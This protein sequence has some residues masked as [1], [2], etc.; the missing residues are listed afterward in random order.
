MLDSSGQMQCLPLTRTQT[1]VWRAQLYGSSTL[2]AD[3]AVNQTWAHQVQTGTIPGVSA[4]GLRRL[5]AAGL[6]AFDS[7]SHQVTGQPF[8][9]ASP[10]EQDLMLALAGNVVLDAVSLPLP[11]VA[12]VP[13]GAAEALF[14]T[15]LSHT[16]AA[17]YGMPEYRGRHD[18]PLWKLIGYDGDTQPL[19]NSIYDENLAGA[20]P[21]QGPNAGFGERGVYVPSGGY[22][23]YRPVSYPAPDQ[24]VL[25]A[26]RAE[27]ALKMLEKWGAKR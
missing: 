12:V 24:S 15:L 26:A 3:A 18:N 7:Y 14:P 11:S 16:F 23:E 19:G 6:D 9:Q 8:A 17:C 22:R 25:D 21:G 1:L 2:T 20:G 4:G 5:Y 13:P 10:Q 27:R